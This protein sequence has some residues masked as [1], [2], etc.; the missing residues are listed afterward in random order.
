[1]GYEPIFYSRIFINQLT[2]IIIV[3]NP[4]LDQVVRLHLNQRLHVEEVLEIAV[5]QPKGRC[6][7][8]LGVNG[9]E[10]V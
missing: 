9:V 2:S 1:M 6:V 8:S 3:D 5:Y 7:D 4:H 10:A